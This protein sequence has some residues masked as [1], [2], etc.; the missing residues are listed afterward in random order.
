MPDLHPNLEHARS[1]VAAL[2]GLAST[3]VTFQT[4]DDHANGD[5]GRA[6]SELVQTIWGSLEDGE[7]PDV[8]AD[9]NRRGAG[10]YITVNE[11]NHGDPL[12]GGEVVPRKA[13]HVTR[14]RALFVD[15]DQGDPDLTGYPAPRIAVRS[16]RG[17]HYYWTTDFVAVER[18]KIAQRTLALRLGTDVVVNDPC[19]VMRLPGFYHRKRDPFL[20]QLLKVN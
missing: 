18:F 13:Q 9:F 8:L 20:V 17:N 1:F 2:T 4:L 7:T 6:R 11:L 12:I 3:V 16:A 14:I 5:R 19:R 15:C 10:V